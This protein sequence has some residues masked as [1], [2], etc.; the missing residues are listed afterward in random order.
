MRIDLTE[1]KND[2]GVPRSYVLE[3]RLGPLELGGERVVLATPVR[4]ALKVTGADGVFWVEGPVT[5]TG[6]F[7]CSRC[8]TSVRVDLEGELRE[9]YSPRGTQTDDEA[10]PFEGD[11]LDVT[12]DVEKALLLAMPMKPVCRPDCRGICPRC[13]RDLN[14]GPCGCRAEDVDPRLAALAGF[15]KDS[16]EI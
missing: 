2:P 10:V 13:G 11:C 7:Q 3:E 4:A 1:A 5:A 16:G 9:K 14:E 6:E 12:R 8:L 15:F